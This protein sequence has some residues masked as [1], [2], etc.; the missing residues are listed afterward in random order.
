MKSI[1]KRSDATF[2]IPELLAPA[3]TKDAFFAAIEGGADA[4]YVSPRVLNARAYGKNF[5]MQEIADLTVTAHKKG[6]KLFVAL[7]SLMKEEE[8]P[9][10]M[11]LLSEIDTIGVDALIIQDLGILRMAKRHFPSLRLHASTL[12]TIHNSLGVEACRKLGFSRVVIAREL[13]LSEIALINR[14]ASVEI[15]VF[16]HGA[17]CFSISGLCRFSSY[18]GGKS[19]TR[20]KCVQPCR[21]TYTWHGY[22]G[23]FFSMDDLCALEVVSELRRL[24]IS[25]LKIEGRLKP[26]SYVYRVVRAYRAVLDAGKKELAAT[27][28]RSRKMLQE[29]MGRP[30]SRGF[31][32]S[33]NPKDI[34]CPTRTANTGTF[35]GKIASVIEDEVIVSSSKTLSSG[36]RLRIVRKKD[37]RQFSVS[38]KSVSDDGRIKFAGDLGSRGTMHDLKGAMVFKSD[39]GGYEKTRWA[40]EKLERFRNRTAL[41]KAA[42]SVR[43]LSQKAG[44][45]RRHPIGKRSTPEVVVFLRDMKEVKGMDRYR[46]VDEFLIPLSRKNLGAASRLGLNQP[47]RKRITWHL[48]PVAW[49]KEVHRMKGLVREAR[50]QGFAKFQITNLWHTMLPLKGAMI[51]SSYELNPLNSEAMLLLKDLGVTRPQFSIETDLGNLKMAMS[52]FGNEASATVYGFIPLFTTRLLHRTYTS[53]DRVRSPKGESFYWKREKDLGCLYPEIPFSF[54]DNGSKLLEAGIAT[55]IL[56]MR[57]SPGKKKRRIRLPASWKGLRHVFRGRKFNLPSKLE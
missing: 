18:F 8:I 43:R 6:I 23:T 13:T 22:K 42:R 21:R 30:L 5:S 57:F 56:D 35:I 15:E 24:G 2:G 17:M 45:T 33:S 19:S 3:G 37:D 52:R 44:H 38:V 32:L 55:W 1:R 27:I 34:V 9:L 49:E 40:G 12:L 41:Q 36:D 20:G 4:V 11:E 7:N 39:S 16:V 26:P 50:K 10:C 31:F 25:S 47:L 29:A 53:R 46:C 51:T 14:R 54:L 48:P 28:D